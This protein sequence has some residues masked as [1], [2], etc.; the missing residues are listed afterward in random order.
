MR[1]KSFCYLLLF[2]FLIL[3]GCSKQDTG[4]IQD[5]PVQIDIS[6]NTEEIEES[7]QD[8][9]LIEDESEKESVGSSIINADWSDYFG[10]FTGAAVIYDTSLNCYQVYNEELAFTQRSP[11]STFKI[12]SSLIALENGIIEPDDSTRTW[13]GEVFW[14]E[15]WNKDIDFS[16]AFHSSCVWYFREIIDEIG[17]DIIQE[18]LNKLQYGNCDMSDWAGKLNTNNKNPAST[19]F[20]LE[21]SLQI[22]PKEQTEVME[23]IFGDNT[24]YSEETLNQLRQVMLLPEQEEPNI[25]IYGKTGMGKDLG[26]TVDAWF[27]GFADSSG[28]KIFFCIYLG[29][30]DDQN[31]T[32]TKA[33]EIALQIVSDYLN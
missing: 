7:T 10:Q 14:N 26:I 28:R 11:C 15:D 9:E 25:S 33:K 17:A 20:W 32:S 5:E 24:E 27:T 31:V 19:G 16:D 13:S 21:S 30:T 2:I 8:M 23:R 18:E 4:H 3:T 1:Y 29:R 12:I 22:S 6:E